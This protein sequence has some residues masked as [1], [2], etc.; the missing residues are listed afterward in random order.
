DYG[1]KVYKGTSDN[2]TT[3]QKT[4]SWFGYKIH[5]IVDSIYELP[6]AYSVTEA[7]VS[8][9][10]EGHQLVDELEENHPSLL[11]R[12]KVMSADK[13]YDDKKFIV[14]LWDE[15]V[16]KPVVDIRNMWKDSD[17]TRL[18]ANFP[19]VVYDYKGNVQ[20]YCPI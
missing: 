6:V 7:S 1:K 16:V 20:C 10:K 13:G 4:V 11:N 8:D 18:L 14:K 9:I 12:T 19:N 15:L 2:G 17:E 5:L 3:W